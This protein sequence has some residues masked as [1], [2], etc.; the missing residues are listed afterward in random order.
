MFILE[1]GTPSAPAKKVC[2]TCTV[3]VHCD[4][5]ATQHHENGVWGGRVHKVNLRVKDISSPVIEDMRPRSS[6]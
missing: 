5:Y 1:R 6:E 4:T 3:T 2:A